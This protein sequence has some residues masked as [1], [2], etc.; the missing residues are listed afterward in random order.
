MEES[1]TDAT[2]AFVVELAQFSG[3]LDLLLSLI[4]DEQLDVYDIPIQGAGP[5]APRF[6]SLV[7]KKDGGAASSREEVYYSFLQQDDRWAPD[8][9]GNWRT[10]RYSPPVFK[11]QTRRLITDHERRH[12]NNPTEQ[13]LGALVRAMNDRVAS[14]RGGAKK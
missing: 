12:V 13:F 9:S 3:P 8:L 1:T 11:V 2:G 4:R 6:R 7:Y 10:L 5:V 14:A